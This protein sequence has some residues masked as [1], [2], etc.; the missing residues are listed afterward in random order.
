MFPCQL[1]P[2]INITATLIWSYE[3]NAYL[4]PCQLY[5]N[6][7]IT[8]TLIW[9]YEYNTCFYS[10]PCQLY[11]YINITATLIWS[12]V[13]NTC[14]ICFPV[15][16]TPTSISLLLL[17]GAMCTI[18]VFVSLSALPQHQYHCY[19]YLELCV[20]YLFYMFPCQLYPYI[21]ITATLIWS[22]VYNTCFYLFPCQLCPNI[23]IT[24]T[25]IWSYVYNTCFYS[26]PCQLYPY[27]NITAT[28]I[29]SYV[30]NTCFICFPVSSTPTSISLLLLS[31]AMCTIPVFVSLSALPQHQYHCYSY[32]ELCVQY[33]F[34]MFPCQ[35]YPY[36]NITA[37]LIWSYVYNT[38]F[39]LFPCQLC[40]N[41]NITAT[42][43]WSY[44]YNTCFYSFPCQLYPYI[45]ITA[46]LIWSYVYNTCFICF[47][48]SSTPTSISLL[49]LSGAMCTIPVFVSLSAL[50]QHQYHCYS[51]LELCVQYLFYMFPCQLYPYINITATLIWSYVYNT[52]FICFPVSS[53][54]TS[55]SL[56]LLSGAMCTIPVLYVSLSALPL[57]QYHCYSYLELCVQYLFYM[58]PCQLYPNINITATFIWSY[59]CNTCFICFPVSSTPTSISL[60]LLSGAMST[61]HIC[62]PVRST[63]TSIS[64]LLLFGAMRTIPVEYLFPCPLQGSKI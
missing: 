15:S 18:P 38:C 54:P 53:T 17:S 31:G 19:S 12:Y 51:Y 1:C 16:S 58:F 43:I 35:L 60:L 30:Y 39:Y 34:Y 13:Y 23:N 55:I 21:N 26:F 63:S 25:L 56:L 52:C 6:I 32:L 7:N 48:V 64:L 9:C 27:I 47:P 45:N 14:F 57:H 22:Y 61:M 62:F 8:A 28:L 33:L 44:V 4:F 2:N 5:P 40:P 11:P 42:L 10:F 37:T 59:V 36:I 3:Y 41:I 29:W 20:Q 24:A 46:T 50:P 49:L